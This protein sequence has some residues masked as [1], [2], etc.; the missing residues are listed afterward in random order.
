[1]G[2][3][4]RFARL[5]L[6]AV[7]AAVEDGLAVFLELGMSMLVK[8]GADCCHDLSDSLVWHAA[9][10]HSIAEDVQAFARA[11]EIGKFGSCDSRDPIVPM[12]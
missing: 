3:A 11:V 12:G 5:V 8:M 4:R 10:G 9:L 2:G 1:M 7:R 6:P